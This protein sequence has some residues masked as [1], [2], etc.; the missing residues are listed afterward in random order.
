MMSIL[1]MSLIPLKTLW[2]AVTHAP[3][4]PCTLAR[5]TRGSSQDAGRW[6]L[7]AAR[8]AAAQAA[9]P[10]SQPGGEAHRPRRT[11]PKPEPEPEPRRTPPPL[12]QPKAGSKF[13]ATPMHFH[14]VSTCGN[15]VLQVWHFS[16]AT[17]VVVVQ[18]SFQAMIRLEGAVGADRGDFM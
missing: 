3:I 18:R 2:P 6:T 9:M 17:L 11:V 5:R 14:G 7:D 16:V 1:L 13:I 8:Q 4:R 12:Q 10:C 15:P